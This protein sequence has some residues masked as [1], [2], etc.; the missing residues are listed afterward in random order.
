MDSKMLFGHG[1]DYKF[2][3]APLEKS[4]MDQY[5]ATGMNINDLELELK[6][7]SNDLVMQAMTQ[8]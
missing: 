6:N 1:V 8:K 3:P 2:D 5:A 7:R 4:Y